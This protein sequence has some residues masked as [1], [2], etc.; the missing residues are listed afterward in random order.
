MY[1]FT[2]P[3]MTLTATAAA[4][5][6]Q[7]RESVI[8][9]LTLSLVGIRAYYSVLNLALTC[10]KTGGH[11]VYTQRPQVDPALVATG[12]QSQPSVRLMSSRSKCGPAPI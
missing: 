10:N 8:V 9:N 3:I 6:R 2:R 12:V 1:V 5:T 4:Q 11:N 7:L